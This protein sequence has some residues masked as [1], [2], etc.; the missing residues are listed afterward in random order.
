MSITDKPLTELEAADIEALIADRAQEHSRLEFKRA[1]PAKKGSGPDTWYSRQEKIGQHG[2]AELIAELV[3]FAN[4]GGGTLIV[5]IEED[6]RRNE[7][8]TACGICEIPKCEEFAQRFVQSAISLVDPPLPSLDV[9][10]IVTGDD[11]AG[12]VVARVSAS[13]LRP[14]RVTKLGNC[15]VR[16]GEN[17]VTMTMTEIRDMI[18]NTRLGMERVEKRLDAL[19]ADFTRY[20]AA[21]ARRGPGSTLFGYRVA[22][23]PMFESLDLGALIREIPREFSPGDVTV[24][25]I[26]RD[27]KT[28]PWQ[29]APIATRQHSTLVPRL[30][31]VEFGSAEEDNARR[32]RFYR[33]GALTA[34]FVGK[35]RAG[36]WTFD[37]T[38]VL[39]DVVN[40][41]RMVAS[42]RGLGGVPDVEYG[43][44]LELR[45]WPDG[46]EPPRDY[47]GPTPTFNFQPR[48]GFE[49]PVS[50]HEQRTLIPPY[51]L[52]RV[53]D[54]QQV[55]RSVW[56]DLHNA[57]GGW[58]TSDIAFDFVEDGV[59]KECSG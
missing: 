29:L 42:V 52:Q 53:E 10:G 34:E 3:A 41:M 21:Q 40:M 11:G 4:S 55:L 56:N 26:T 24:C 36:R 15:F 38:W 22:G 5:G 35:E 49:H 46:R 31:C 17:R 16:R 45:Y 58:P 59:P 50:L 1:V 32:R 51:S 12:V 14:H 30:G 28:R 6:T 54:F 27:G 57:A 25:L 44:Q 2:K 19:G 8:A 7:P 13:R 9:R 23:V 18:I 20:L 37:A 43:L 33:D 39:G 48:D 47:S